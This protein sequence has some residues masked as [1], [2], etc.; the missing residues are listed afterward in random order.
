[1]V[2]SQTVAQ[3]DA[4]AEDG[5]GLYQRAT[6]AASLVRFVAVED[7]T[8]SGSNDFL[9]VCT[10]AGVRFVADTN[11]APAQTDVGTTADLTDHDTL[12]ESASSND[13]F[14][15]EEILGATTDQKVL[16]YFVTDKTS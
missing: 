7:R 8:D 2:A 4:L 3:H 5:N 10:T 15:I 6:S 14:F 12:N 11:A 16:G 13:V 9:L 1:M